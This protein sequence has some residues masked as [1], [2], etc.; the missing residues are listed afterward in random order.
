MPWIPRNDLYLL[1]LHF[2]S[3]EM[4]KLQEWIKGREVISN[5]DLQRVYYLQ[6]LPPALCPLVMNLSSP[7][8]EFEATSM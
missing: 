3:E 6:Q 1:L 2:L 8:L 5:E 4:R 7:T